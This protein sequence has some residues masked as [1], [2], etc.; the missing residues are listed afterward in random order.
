MILMRIIL[1]MIEA[2]GITTMRIW[3]VVSIM[4]ELAGDTS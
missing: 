2:T 4:T 1:M 3:M